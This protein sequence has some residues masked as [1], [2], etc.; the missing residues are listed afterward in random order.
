MKHLLFLCGP[1]GIGKTAIGREIVR[2][3][4]NTAYVDSDS[5]RMMNPF[6]LDDT[7]IPTIAKNISDLIINYLNCQAVTNVVFSYGFHGRR[8]EVFQAVMERL[9]DMPFDFIPLLLWCG[10]DENVKRMQADNR[11]IE[12]VWRT[13]TVSRSS[14]ND[15][16]YPR[17]D[18]TDFSISIAAE[19][20]ITKAG[21]NKKNA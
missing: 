6:V 21:L 10:E 1:N 5:C 20:I 19:M 2:Q 18:I 13:L 17:L 9:S 7:T 11:S 12:Q 15:I 8:K 3:L 14:F 4:P 16:P